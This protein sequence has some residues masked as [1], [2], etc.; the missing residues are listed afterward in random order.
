M[1]DQKLQISNEYSRPTEDQQENPIK[2]KKKSQLFH[3]IKRNE[4]GNDHETRWDAKYSVRSY[5]VLFCFV[6]SSAVIG[7]FTL[8]H[9]DFLDI[10]W[11]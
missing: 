5:P 4:S 11:F 6:L 2:K 9:S 7:S 8:G 1:W 10:V 3:L